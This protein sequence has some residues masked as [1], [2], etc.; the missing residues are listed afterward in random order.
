ME[1][2]SLHQTAIPV[3]R[4]VVHKSCHFSLTNT[5]R[6]Q[7]QDSPI[8]KLQESRGYPREM[9][10][11][12]ST[13]EWYTTLQKTRPPPSKITYGISEGMLF[14]A[15]L[16][17]HWV[18]QVNVSSNPSSLSR[19]TRA[20]CVSSARCLSGQPCRRSIVARSIITVLMIRGTA[21]PTDTV[22]APAT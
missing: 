22:V 12:E 9:A 13:S 17:G 4:G 1:Q 16:W 6:G 7:A 19:D 20:S 2:R 15:R 8:L 14:S 21:N 5:W 11:P 10:I 3:Q 18:A